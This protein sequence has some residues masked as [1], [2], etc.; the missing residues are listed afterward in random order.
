MFLSV[1]KTNSWHIKTEKSYNADDNMAFAYST[2]KLPAL[3]GNVAWCP[4]NLV[5][6]VW[7]TG[8]WMKAIKVLG[9]V[10]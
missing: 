7:A 1:A 2:A 10:K 6:Y 3:S 9:T 5:D 4:Q 8:K